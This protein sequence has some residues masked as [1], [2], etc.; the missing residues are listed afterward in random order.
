MKKFI[1]I[2]I[3]LFTSFNIQIFAQEET[4]IIGGELLTKNRIRINDSLPL[5]WNENRLDIQL[6]RKIK[7]F[8]KFNANVWFRSFNF[9]ENDLQNPFY[10]SNLTLPFSFEVREAY[11]ELYNFIIKN[12]DIT[13]GRQRIAWGTADGINPTDNLSPY[14]LSDIWDFTNNHSG[15][16]AIDFRYYIKDTKIEGVFLPYFVPARLPFGDWWQA[17]GR[18]EKLPDSMIV[19]EVNNLIPPITLNIKYNKVNYNYILP[20]NNLTE[21]PGY[22]IKIAKNLL[23]FDFSLSYV[24][25]RDALPL[26]NKTTVLVDSVS[27]TYDTAFL[28]VNNELIYPKINIFGFDF[29]GTLGNFGIRGELGVYIPEKKFMVNVESTDPNELINIPPLEF[30]VEGIPKDSIVLDKKP[31]AKYVLGLDYFFANGYYINLQYFHGFI[32]ERGYNNLNNYLSLH[33][34][35]KFLDEKIIFSPSDFILATY[36]FNN[37]EN[38]FAYVY[39]PS[40]SYQ[41]TDNAKIELGIRIIDG[42][43]NGLFSNIKDKDHF[44]IKAKYSF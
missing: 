21:T 23:G 33:F 22:G 26:L 2:T 12:L 38:N 30:E 35:M 31:Y 24:Y 42:K 27:S 25:T 19:K 14:D 16:D 7:D 4:L 39:M 36:D 11:F 1:F 8:G 6:T 41:A 32:N 18:E 40:L 13:I 34:E 17:F 10:T 28:T 44:F 20:A 15:I 9:T 3:A 43:G 5:S 29:A 37:P